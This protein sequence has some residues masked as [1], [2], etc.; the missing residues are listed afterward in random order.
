MTKTT[1]IWSILSPERRKSCIDA[2]IAHFEIERD[3][4]IGEIAAEQI[5]DLILD[6]VYP[7]IYNKAVTDS[8]QVLEDKM[9]DIKI[10]LDLLKRA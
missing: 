7:E 1:E 2:L 5:L 8:M 10:D 4:Q 3:E 9:T 6:Q